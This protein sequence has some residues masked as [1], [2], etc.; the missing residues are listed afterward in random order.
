MLWF[1]FYCAFLLDLLTVLT[2]PSTLL[3]HY[4][5]DLLILFKSFTYCYLP[6]N[7][8][9]LPNPLLR[10]TVTYFASSGRL[11]LLTITYYYLLL[12][13]VT[14][15]Y[16]YLLLTVLLLTVLLLT[17]HFLISASYVQELLTS[18]WKLSFF[19]LERSVWEP[20]LKLLHCTNAKIEPNSSSYNTGQGLQHSLYSP[21]TL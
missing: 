7:Y 9:Y 4:L 2:S 18:C 19:T 3:I 11:L 21:V 8:Y 10:S 13:T 5:V 15:Y 12:L 16:T 6:V 20:A 1:L 17:V 14:Y